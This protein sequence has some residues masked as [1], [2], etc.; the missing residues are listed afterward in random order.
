MP[1]ALVNNAQRP[2]G[3]PQTVDFFTIP[4][5][6]VCGRKRAVKT[7]SPWRTIIDLRENRESR[8]TY[9]WCGDP[10]CP[11]HAVVVSPDHPDVA[12]K[13]DYSY[14]V[15][16]M[17]CVLRWRDRRTYEEIRAE[18]KARFDIE[19]SLNTVENILRIYEIGCAD[20]YQPEYVEKIQ[21]NGGV[22]LTIDGMA[23]LRGKQGLYIAYDYLTGLA[24]GSAKLPNQK[25]ETIAAFLEGV[26]RRVAE[27]L[28]VSVKF[29]GVVSD[30]LPSQRLA[31]EKVFP[32]VPHCL[33]HY[34]FFNLVLQDPKA[35]DSKL[36]T[37]A[38]KVLR[39]LYDIQRYKERRANGGGPVEDDF[40][41][42]ILE[43]AWELSNWRR[44]RKDPCFTSL[45][46]YDRLTGLA[47]IVH[48]AVDKLD[49]GKVVIAQAKVIRRLD[50]ALQA[51]LAKSAGG[52]AELTRVHAHLDELS[53][54]LGD[55]DA[56]FKVGLEQLRALRDRLRKARFSPNVGEV[57]RSFVEALMKFVR[58]KGEHLFNY[59][60]VPGAP[61]TNNAHELAYKQL[62]HLLRRVIGHSAANEY[63]L[64]HGE[65]LVFVNP[66][67]SHEGVVEILRRVDHPA[68]RRQIARERRSRDSLTF[69]THDAEKWGDSLAR[70]YVMLED[71]EHQALVVN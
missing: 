60:K 19:M 40:V 65:R 12:P 46:L 22:I 1:S 63:L 54:I 58:T 45:E 49:A 48:A 28:G 7:R 23:P 64:A 4:T 35:L 62:K 55:L 47:G 11:G 34:H 71:L 26:K 57:E 6:E 27:E 2:Y 50:S 70:L 20:A 33:C 32:G 41:D 52:V 15:Q 29:V 37:R 69:I 42:A 53:G 10:F 21:A 38:R 59:K 17:V 16:A 18:M 24:L 14:D 36:V 56:S 68:A 9:R 43:H 13:S 67:D 66:G 44:R 8:S 25:Q 30:A 39:A 51:L 61:T 31:I 5:C 3:E